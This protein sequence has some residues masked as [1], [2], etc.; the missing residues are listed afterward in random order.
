M[1][2]WDKR[3]ASSIGSHLR[4]QQKSPSGLLP[5]MHRAAL[6]LK[7]WPGTH[8]GAVSI[9]HWGGYLDEFILRFNRRKSR[10]RGKPFYRLVLQ[11]V[12]VEQATLSN[13]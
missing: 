12:A 4:G 5:R 9:E 11:A 2:G 7:R 1:D 6:L 3:T 10:S 13:L 8:Q